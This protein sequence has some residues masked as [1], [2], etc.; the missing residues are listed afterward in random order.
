MVIQKFIIII[1]TY[2][3][4]QEIETIKQAVNAI[5]EKTVL[6]DSERQTLLTLAEELK[7]HVKQTSAQ[8]TLF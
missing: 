3:N 5:K 7:E 6:S 1:L 2:C 4:M 8:I